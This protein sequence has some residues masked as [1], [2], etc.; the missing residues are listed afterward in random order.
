MCAVTA[1]VSSMATLGISMHFQVRRREE[2]IYNL[3]ACYSVCIY[4]YIYI[5]IYILA[6][7]SA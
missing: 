4:I 5:Y 6:V 2:F 3:F 7:I 1:I